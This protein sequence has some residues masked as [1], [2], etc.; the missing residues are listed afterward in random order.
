[1][2]R[3]YGNGN[4]SNDKKTGQNQHSRYRIKKSSSLSGLNETGNPETN[5]STKKKAK[6]GNKTM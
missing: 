1:M 6:G 5:P 4:S 2:P 3:D